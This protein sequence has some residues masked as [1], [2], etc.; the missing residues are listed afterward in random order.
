MA[1]IQ[2]SERETHV[3]Y[4]KIVTIR[5]GENDM[6]EVSRDGN[7]I[8]RKVPIR[9]LILFLIGLPVPDLNPPE[10]RK[11]DYHTR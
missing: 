9:D 3:R 6:I 5:S 7:W 8:I 1:F 10:S 4:E 2:T 11:P